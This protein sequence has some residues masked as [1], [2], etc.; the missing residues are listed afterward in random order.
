[1]AEPQMAAALA[2]LGALYQTVACLSDKNGARVVRL[3]HWTLGRDLILRQYSSP[4]PAYDLLV[5]V[6]HP[7]LPAVYESRHFPDGQLVLEEAIDG[8]TAAEVMVFALAASPCAT[9]A[10]VSPVA[11]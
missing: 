7:N 6:R 10:R 5:G 3:R 2:E 8:I 1:M 11:S 9:A 4:V